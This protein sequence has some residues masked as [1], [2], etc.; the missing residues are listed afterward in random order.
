MH[1]KTTSCAGRTKNYWLTVY[2]LGNTSLALRVGV[3]GGPSDTSV[4]PM[5]RRRPTGVSDLW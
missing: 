5:P 1:D 2:F 4:G 3:G